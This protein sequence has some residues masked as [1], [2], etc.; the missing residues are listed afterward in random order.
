MSNL[1]P[2]EQT[3]IA[4]SPEDNTLQLSLG[5]LESLESLI[6]CLDDKVKS[7]VVGEENLTVILDIT[8]RIKNTLDII[9]DNINPLELADKARLSGHRFVS[10][11]HT[12]GISGEVVR[13]RERGE[14][15]VEIANKFSI[16]IGTVSRYLKYYDKLSKAK[17]SKIKANSIMNT[18]ERLEDI[19]NMCLRQLH[20]LEGQNDDVHVKYIG[21]LRQTIGLAAQVSEKIA[22]YKAYEQFKQTVEEILL[23]EL[24]ERRMEIV[25]KLKS[26]KDN[27]SLA[28]PNA[29]N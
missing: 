18:T 19:M 11:I 16:S 15:I 28:L 24:P 25:R 5:L 9:T 7:S 12:L 20:R 21:E 23:S 22:T 29:V 27:N 6:I 10:I 14:P 2:V 4:S 8:S 3:D 17:Q 13:C 26:L 1:I